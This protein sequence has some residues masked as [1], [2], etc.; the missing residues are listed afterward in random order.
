[1]PF[2]ALQKWLFIFLLVLILQTNSFDGVFYYLKSIKKNL[3]VWYNTISRTPE[4]QIFEKRFFEKFTGH[5]FCRSFQSKQLQYEWNFLRNQYFRSYRKCSLLP[6]SK[7]FKTK[8]FHYKKK[9]LLEIFWKVSQKKLR[10]CSFLVGGGVCLSY[11]IPDPTTYLKPNKS[12]LT[13]TLRQ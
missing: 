2:L 5:L 13:N 11:C 3:D 7:F 6:K 1:M 10:A 4:F 12:Y 9:S 8:N